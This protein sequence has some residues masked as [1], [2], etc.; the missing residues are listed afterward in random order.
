ML[1]TFTYI[2]IFFIGA[3]FTSF[4]HLIVDRFYD[5]KTIL[6]KS[7]CPSCHKELKLIDVI[8]FLGYLINKG[9]CRYCKANIPK[10]HIIFEAIG[11]LLTLLGFVSFSFSIEYL[12]YLILI[13]VLLIESISDLKKFLVI[14]RVWLIAM[15][16]L[17]MLQ[18]MNQSFLTHLLS[19]SVIF[20]ILL[21]FA[22]IASKV[23]KKEALGGGDIK[24]YIFI[25]WALTL[26]EVFFSLF[27]AAFF[28]LLYAIIK[29][30]TQQELP[31]VPFIF[32]GSAISILYGQQLIDLYLNWLG[33]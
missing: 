28:G 23:L 19:S 2:I 20:I 1:N 11:G 7:E 12:I 32:I 8:P 10:S 25:G 24:L 21:I 4:F 14:D 6:G 13:S 22:T 17:I 9:S 15:P 33:V 16:I 27:L 5:K 30:R 3:L 26:Q 18:I 29:K 31:F